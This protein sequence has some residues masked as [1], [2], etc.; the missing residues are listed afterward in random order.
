[1]LRD[2]GFS[3]ETKEFSTVFQQEHFCYSCVRTLL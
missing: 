3:G 1:V 2:E